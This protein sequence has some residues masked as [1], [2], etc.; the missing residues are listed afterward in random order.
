MRNIV[1]TNIGFVY[2]CER[3]RG[4][5]GDVMLECSLQSFKLVHKINTKKITECK[6]HKAFFFLSNM[7]EV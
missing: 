2:E 5:E 3:M 4:R 6:D 7:F 1:T